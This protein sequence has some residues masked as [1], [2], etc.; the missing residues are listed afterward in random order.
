MASG[1]FPAPD[2]SY[3]S[4]LRLVLRATDSTGITT[5]VTRD[6]QPQTVNIT[7]DSAPVTSPRLQLGFNSESV[8]TPFTR[9]V[10]VGS[11]MT[12]SAPAQ[13]RRAA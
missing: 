13:S 5:T 3:P 2:H 10:I 12:V 1:S 4:F 11:A 8:T 6:L 9:T 7:F